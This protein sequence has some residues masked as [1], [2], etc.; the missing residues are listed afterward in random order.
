[1]R[2]VKEVLNPRD[3]NMLNAKGNSSWVP[4]NP[5]ELLLPYVEEIQEEDRTNVESR[6]KKAKEIYDGY[7]TLINECKEIRETIAAYCKDVKVKIAANNLPLADAVKRV[8]GTDGTEITFEM[9]NTAIYYIN[10]IAKNNTPS[11]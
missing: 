11:L 6:R 8:F 10:K 9:Y 4:K 5:R 2:D 1:M 7:G 3:T